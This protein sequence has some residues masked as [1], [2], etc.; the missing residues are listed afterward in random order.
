MPEPSP[1]LDR[2]FHALSDSTRRAVVR[3]L[4]RGPGA[5]GA[6][7]APFAMALPSFMQHLDVLTDAG[8]LRSRKVGRVRI[9]ELAPE[10]LDLVAGW[11]DEQRALWTDRLD[12]LDRHLTRGD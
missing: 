7:A 3:R 6:L 1:D 4:A 2:I 10:R 5:V 8:L 9:C 12:Q 11:L